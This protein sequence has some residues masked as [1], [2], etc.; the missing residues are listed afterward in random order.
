MD[1]NRN[2]RFESW[3]VLRDHKP[4]RI[5]TSTSDNA[6]FDQYAVFPDPLRLDCPV[7]YRVGPGEQVKSDACGLMRAR[8]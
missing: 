1:A 7:V 5:A 6:I 8:K 3:Q 2:G 4:V